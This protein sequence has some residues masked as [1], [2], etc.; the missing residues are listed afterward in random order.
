M[1]HTNYVIIPYKKNKYNANRKKL[2]GCQK[3]YVAYALR[4]KKRNYKKT[5]VENIL[6][7]FTEKK[8][9]YFKLLINAVQCVPK[10][11]VS[12]SVV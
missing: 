1:F 8:I 5:F 10:S 2:F 4:Y 3:K 9:C 12:T 6:L 7:I 11:L